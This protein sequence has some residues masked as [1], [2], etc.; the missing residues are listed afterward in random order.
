MEGTAVNRRNLVAVA[1][2]LGAL[3]LLYRDVVTGMVH[4]WASDDRYSHGFLIPAIAAYIAWERRHRFFAAPLR[5]SAFGLLAVVASILL[6]AFGV[7][8]ADV[9]LARLSLVGTLTGIVLFLG[10]WARLQIVV[11]P[12]AILLLMIPLP[13]LVF[14]Q[15]EF[16]MQLIASRVGEVVIKAVDIPV[17]REG[18]LLIL[19][20]VTLEVA[21]ACSGVR[22]MIA[23]IALGIAFGYAPDSRLWTRALV[24]LATVP[25]AVGVN[26][27]RVAGTGIATHFYGR[28]AAEGLPHQL[29][30]FAAFIAAF[31]ALLLFHRL[32]LL[33][34][35]DP[36]TARTRSAP[37]PVA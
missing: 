35:Q 25:V 34:A 30:G 11:F 5:P 18:N 22:T 24:V 36:A 15:I 21:E 37:A 33:I 6:L 13:Q 7:V 4:A 28:A 27:A 20:N 26:S 14:D 32:L 31:A 12:L 17:V 10:G 1:L 9:F 8:G 29:A 19:S 23:L 2:V 3:A 16:P